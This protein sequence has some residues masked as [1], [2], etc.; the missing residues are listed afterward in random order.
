MVYIDISRFSEPEE[1][2]I[3]KVGLTL[4]S[5]Y[6]SSKYKRCVKCATKYWEKVRKSWRHII[7]SV[8][9]HCGLFDSYKE[10]SV[11]NN[12][13]SG[14]DLKPFLNPDGDPFERYKLL[15][16]AAEYVFASTQELQSESNS[17][18]SV[19]TVSFKTYFLKTVKR[20][21]INPSG[22]NTDITSRLLNLCM[23]KA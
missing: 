8:W 4:I 12:L 2:A 20:M 3:D 6:Y 7:L 17:G 14:Y 18:K 22:I 21:R 16:K 19:K 1:A 9:N 15:A 13:F 23:Q 10:F 5:L 11:L